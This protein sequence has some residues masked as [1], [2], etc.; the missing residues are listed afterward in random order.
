MNMELLNKQLI[1]AVK[2]QKIQQAECFIQQGADVNTKDLDGNTPLIIAI[3]SVQPEMVKLLIDYNVD[4]NKK[5]RDN[6]T[7]FFWAAYVQ[8]E[9]CAKLLMK[10]GARTNKG[11]T[12]HTGIYDY[13]KYKNQQMKEFIKKIIPVQQPK[14]LAKKVVAHQTQYGTALLYH[15]AVCQQRIN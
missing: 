4:I 5:G 3:Q 15:N 9:K 10:A 11:M 14:H 1:K 12:I 8:C 6:K 2:E 13:D 7:P